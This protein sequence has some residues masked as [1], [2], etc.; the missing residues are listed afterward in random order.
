MAAK[1]AQT[2]QIKIPDEKLDWLKYNPVALGEPE[3]RIA[4]WGNQNAR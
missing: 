3:N 1:L 4:Y 2:V